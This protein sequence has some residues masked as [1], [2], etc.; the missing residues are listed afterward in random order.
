MEGRAYA[1][2]AFFVALST[3]A[4]LHAVRTRSVWWWALYAVAVAGAAYSH[5]TAIF[6]LAAQAA[7]ALWVSRSDL[8]LALLAHGLALLLYLPWL[9]HVR[10]KALSTFNGLYP[11][12]VHRVATDALRPVIGFPNGSLGGIPGVLGLIAIAVCC[13]V[14]LVAAIRRRRPPEA[15]AAPAPTERD[16]PRWRDPKV[17]LIAILALATPVGV[18]LYSLLDVDIWLPRGIYASA[19]AQAVVLGAVL[20]APRLAVRVACVTVVLATC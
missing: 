4:L 5:Y 9:P 1:T 15:A 18:L 7:W 16:A 14:G 10:G 6:L 3:L 2:M 11:L 19:P 12:S 8:R 13:A 17:V 20:T